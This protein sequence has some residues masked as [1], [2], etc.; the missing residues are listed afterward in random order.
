MPIW[1][2]FNVRYGLLA[3]NTTDGSTC[4]TY[5][6]S[7]GVFFETFRQKCVVDP[8]TGRTYISSLFRNANGEWSAG[9]L[10]LDENGNEALRIGNSNL[11]SPPPL[12]LDPLRKRIYTRHWDPTTYATSL[13]AYDAWTGVK[14]WDSFE[15]TG[16]EVDD[17]P[18]MTKNL[19]VFT[20]KWESSSQP[21]GVTALDADSMTLIWQKP[22]ISGAPI[23]TGNGQLWLRSDYLVYCL[24]VNTGAVLSTLT[25]GSLSSSGMCPDENSLYIN[26]AS[27]FAGTHVKRI[28]D[29]SQ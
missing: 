19:L 20:Q 7:E 2:D 1:D 5:W 21:G 18:V 23:V 28:S 12:V 3:L 16:I 10:C 4:F 6:A 27:A 26:Y 14:L 17:A 11:S 29:S 15:N 22:W 9:I 25:I 8:S 24:D 13:R